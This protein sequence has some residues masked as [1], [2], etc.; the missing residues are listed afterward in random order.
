MLGCKA[1]SPRNCGVVVLPLCPALMVVGGVLPFLVA[2]LLWHVV[3]LMTVLCRSLSYPRCTFHFCGR[4]IGDP[5]SRPA[6]VVT[7]LTIPAGLHPV[8]APSFDASQGPAA[9][10]VGPLGLGATLVLFLY[11]LLLCIFPALCLSSVQNCMS[12]LGLPRRTWSCCLAA[13]LCTWA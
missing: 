5:P 2:A 12:V 7:M 10:A 3:A 4:P 13:D 6:P 1:R 11:L 8:Q 9:L